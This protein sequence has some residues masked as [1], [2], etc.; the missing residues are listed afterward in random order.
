MPH[1]PGLRLRRHAAAIVASAV[2]CCVRGAGAVR[3]ERCCAVLRAWRTTFRSPVRAQGRAHVH[4][5]TQ[6]RWEWR[7]ET[8][9]RQ[10]SARAAPPVARI[11]TCDNW[12]SAYRKSSRA[13]AALSCQGG[14]GGSTVCRCRPRGDLHVRMCEVVPDARTQGQR[15]TTA[16]P[17]VLTPRPLS[18][19]QTR[20]DQSTA[21]GGG[22]ADGDERDRAREAA[23]AGAQQ[24]PSSDELAGWRAGWSVFSCCLV[25]R[26]MRT[27]PNRQIARARQ[28][29][30][31][32]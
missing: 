4:A 8:N 14:T 30:V 16:V 31:C 24:L 17:R 5:H 15:A 25:V 2:G 3:G 10:R 13:H 11:I 19:A 27:C 18:R 12:L 28:Q 7:W 32:S 29:A 23:A 21:R 1:Q 22:G 26:A 6:A 9:A 20:V